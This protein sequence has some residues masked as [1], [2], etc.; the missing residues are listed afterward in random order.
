MNSSSP[1]VLA[2]KRGISA[3]RENLAPAL[4]LQLLLGLLVGSYFLWPSS[5]VLLYKLSA[6]KQAGGMWFSMAATG[7][8]GGFLAELSK[9]CFGQR[10]RCTR[11]NIED[12]LFNFIMLGLAGGVVHLFY[13]QQAR[14]FGDHLAWSVILSKTTVDMLFFT[15]IWATPFQTI[16]WLWKNNRY[17][18]AVVH[19]ELYDAYFT[20]H[21]LPLLFMQ[22]AFWIPVVMMTYSLPL[23]LQFPF[24]LVAMATWGLLLGALT[25]SSVKKETGN[26]QTSPVVAE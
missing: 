14:W 6:W 15:P 23:V 10:G 17:S 18:W 4:V 8:A 22:W 5:A 11:A 26:L 9:V 21:Y 16:F 7:F 20:R 2:A 25:K 1:L 13:E 12:A 3:V 19:R 24:F